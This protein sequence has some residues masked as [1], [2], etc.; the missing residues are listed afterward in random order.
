[1]YVY[2]DIEQS[3]H[4][5]YF[6]FSRLGTSQ[7]LSTTLDLFATFESGIVHYARS[8]VASSAT[9]SA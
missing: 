3:F 5:V 9:T 7:A 4:R 1:M 8:E 6:R 2:A